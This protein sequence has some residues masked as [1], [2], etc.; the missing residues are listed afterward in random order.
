MRS[1][2]PREFVEAEGTTEFE[3]RL[4]CLAKVLRAEGEKETNGR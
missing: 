3:A 2:A 1:I 4:R